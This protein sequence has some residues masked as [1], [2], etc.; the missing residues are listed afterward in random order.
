ML[1]LHKSGD[2]MEPAKKGGERMN[3]Y[4]IAKM[5]ERIGYTNNKEQRIGGTAAL[6]HIVHCPI[7][8][9]N[10]NS[11]NIGKKYVGNLLRI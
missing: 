6:V 3:Y 9:L 4:D 10:Q 7:K 1:C 11:I 2:R 8:E 5:I